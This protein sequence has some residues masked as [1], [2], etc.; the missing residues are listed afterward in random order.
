MSAPVNESHVMS[1]V[2][3]ASGILCTRIRSSYI[4]IV[5]PNVILCPLLS[6]RDRYWPGGRFPNS[7]NIAKGSFHETRY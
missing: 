2:C 7:N 4:V 3:K 1:I 5:F 6:S